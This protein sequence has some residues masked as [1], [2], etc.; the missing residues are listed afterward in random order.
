M[1]EEGRGVKKQWVDIRLAARLLLKYPA[2]T[3]VGGLSMAVAVAAL[4]GTFSITENL[5]DPRLPFDGGERVVAVQN[6]DV[7]SGAPDGTRRTDYLLWR[8][9]L[10]SV[11]DIGAFAS[12]DREVI[13]DGGASRTL[14]VA[15]VTSTAF[16]VV[17]TPPL[18]GRHLDEADEAAWASDVVVISSRVWE[19]LFA[20]NPAVI[21]QTLRISGIPHE[22]VGVMPR[23]FRFPLNHAAWTPLRLDPPD[24]EGLTGL[25]LSVFGRLAEGFDLDRAQA[26]LTVLGR[27]AANA[28]PQTHANLRPRVVPYAHQWVGASRLGYAGA[29]LGLVIL[30]L[31]VVANVGALVLART[32]T[33]EG[34]I[35]VRRALGAGREQIVAQLTVEAFFLVVL[36]VAVGLAAASWGVSVVS[37][38]MSDMAFG[39]G[40]LPFWWRDGL[41][42]ETI[43]WVGILALVATILC[44]AIPAIILTN[45]REWGTLQRTGSSNWSP[46][47]GIGG[48][49]VVA[50]QFAL[51][52]GLLT[53]AVAEWP[54]MVQNEAAIAGLSS[55]AYLT[56]VVRLSEVEAGV[57]S[58]P[59]RMASVR[60]ALLEQLAVDPGVAG[61]TMATALPGMFHPQVRTQTDR[62]DDTPDD[63]PIRYS[64]VGPAFFDVMDLPLRGGRVFSE[65]DFTGGTGHSVVVV[66]ESYA[67]ERLAGTGVIGRRIRFV[68][69]AGGASEWREVVG[70]VQD[71]GMN[72]I[73]PSRPAGVYIPL[74]DSQRALSLAVRTVDG[75]SPFAPQLR[76]LEAS[77]GPPV[78]IERVRPLDDVIRSNRAQRRMEYV[79]IAVGTFAVLLLTMGGLSAVTSF[80]VSRRTHEMG[81]RTAL[82]AHPVRVAFDIYSGAARRLGWGVVVGVPTGVA[83]GSVVLEGGSVLVS[84]KVSLALIAVGLVAC[85]PATRRLLAV[86]PVDAIRGEV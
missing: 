3:V 72:S 25:T 43:W 2:L 50:T 62:P 67:R 8:D 15:A 34:E 48:K 47:T 39:M 1:Q 31:V 35:A 53:M 11:E 38:V 66:N 23:E 77:L 40:G 51:S 6:W 21:G 5:L 44:G 24:E 78:A 56:A 42:P 54:D 85:V 59:G 29:R 70:V 37:R 18:L 81:I 12:N 84:F 17:G 33:R 82:G 28:S 41:T 68:S 86:D 69:R 80:F 83:L 13:R 20:G 49:A 22:V 30:L 71:F 65:D 14:R 4:A 55:D 61:A 74:D 9:E 79:A 76:S 64:A 7:T 36:S 45:R 26:E 19:D 16:G 57:P 52:V 10:R 75:P 60:R 32:L 63:H 46:R 58:A 73:D 27:R